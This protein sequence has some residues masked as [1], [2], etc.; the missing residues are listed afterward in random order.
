MTDRRDE[1]LREF[2]TLYPATQVHTLGDRVGVL[3]PDH[4]LP[5]GW[6]K[7]HT[8]LVWLLEPG[9]PVTQPDC[10][11]MDEDARS[12]PGQ[13]P[14]NTRLQPCPLG[15]GSTRRWVSWHLAQWNPAKHNL[16]AWLNCIRRGIRHATGHVP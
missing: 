16:E 13:P 9:Y 6:T 14:V 7:S 5:Q 4:P 1:D 10:F 3:L 2:L 8:N 11:W 12:L 15:T